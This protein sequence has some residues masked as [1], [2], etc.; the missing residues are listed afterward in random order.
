M[1]DNSYIDPEDRYEPLMSLRHLE[2]LIENSP[3]HTATPDNKR[4][5]SKEVRNLA[6]KMRGKTHDSS[7]LI[8]SATRIVVLLVEGGWI[9]N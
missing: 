3:P 4:R 6:S 2:C 7:E 9:P 5:L 1:F 8:R